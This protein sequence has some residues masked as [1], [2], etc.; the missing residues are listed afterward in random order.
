VDE[1]GQSILN[2][3]GGAEHGTLM[4]QRMSPKAPG[5]GS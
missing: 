3:V 2:A 1:R 4:D 5:T